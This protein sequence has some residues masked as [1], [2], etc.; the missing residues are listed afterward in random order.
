VLTRPQG[1]CVTLGRIILKRLS[2]EALL[3]VPFLLRVLQ[4]QAGFLGAL[5][6]P[7]NAISNSD[8]AVINTNTVF[9]QMRRLWRL[10]R[11]LLYR[12]RHEVDDRH[13]PLSHS[14]KRRR[15]SRVA[16]C[17]QLLTFRRIRIV[18]TLILTL[19][20]FQ[21]LSSGIPSTYEDV[22]FYERQ[23]PQHNISQ[24]LAHGTRYL[25]IPERLWGHGLNNILQETY[26]PLPYSQTIQLK[27]SWQDSVGT[28]STQGG[29]IIRV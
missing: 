16:A 14:N 17:W 9:L 19:F 25:R 23:L 10:N 8:F 1:E 3:A 28:P 4:S 2:I 15:H 27:P 21:I 12:P 6:S 26:V 20:T 11:H 5:N 22:R 24:A 13:L 18:F 7:I 29:A